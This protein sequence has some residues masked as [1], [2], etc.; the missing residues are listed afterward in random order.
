MGESKGTTKSCETRLVK[1]KVLGEPRK[2]MKD[3]RLSMVKEP[4][5]L[6]ET[7]TDFRVSN[8]KEE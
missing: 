5:E 7:G 1:R 8:I 2:T 6:E 4:H 3:P